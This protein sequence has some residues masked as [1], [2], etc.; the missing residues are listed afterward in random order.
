M[1]IGDSHRAEVDGWP[2]GHRNPANAWWC[3]EHMRWEC[4]ADSRRTETRCHGSARKYTDK[5]KIH[6]GME[7][8]RASNRGLARLTAWSAE[9]IRAAHAGAPPVSPGEAVLGMLSISYM[10][11]HYYAALLEAQVEEEG[12]RPGE[13]APQDAD[14]W[15]ME[16]YEAG[17]SAHPEERI[18]GNPRI[19]PSSGLIGHTIAADKELGLYAS[20][21]AVR[22][23]VVLE[24]QE[25]DR[26][27]K[28]AKV[29]A[30]MG[31]A[32]R[33]ISLAENQGEAM[34]GMVKRILD[35]LGLTPEQRQLVSVVVPQEFRRLK[36]IEPGANVA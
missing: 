31:I 28:Y 32:E 18:R 12:G 15:L 9:G 23:L 7:A 16:R 6:S 24:A 10:R 26:C 2:D 11:A 27:V 19:P 13:G 25:R 36:E 5:C 34:V 14:S 8:E 3:R 21:E 30:D 29:A 33:Q 17:E 4:T 1:P 20:G 35:A 22:A